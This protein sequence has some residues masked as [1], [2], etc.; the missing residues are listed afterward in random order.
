[1]S[2]LTFS[3]G[4]SIDTSGELRLL[5]LSDGWYV[6]GEGV[7]YPV[8]NPQEGNEII[9]DMKKLRGDE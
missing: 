3:D 1:M 2:K 6:V 7:L 8:D 9:E 4:V 5:R